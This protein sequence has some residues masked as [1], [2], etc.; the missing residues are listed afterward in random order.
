MRNKDGN[1]IGEKYGF[2]IIAKLRVDQITLNEI[3]KLVLNVKEN[4]FFFS[5]IL[6]SSLSYLRYYLSVFYIKIFSDCLSTASFIIFIN[7]FRFFLSSLSF[8]FSN[9]GWVSSVSII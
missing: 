7:T 6:P 2:N 4:Q 9:F 5:L 3:F 1:H 8:L